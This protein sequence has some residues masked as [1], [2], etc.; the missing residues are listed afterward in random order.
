MA[1]IGARAVAIAREWI[2]TPYRHQAA[3]KGHGADCLGLIR[4]VWRG[5]YGA[6]PET[7]PPYSADWM[8]STGEERLWAAARRWLAPSPGPA[9][10]E[11]LLFRMAERG[12]AKHLAILSE[13]DPAR[14][15]HAY[16]G[17]S[18]LESPLTESWARRVVARFRFPERG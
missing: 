3:C 2:G 18:V 14:I 16:S 5:L 11:V 15:I 1:D 10:G 17:R 6:E 9:R 13:T 7:P 12:P 8:E 4:G